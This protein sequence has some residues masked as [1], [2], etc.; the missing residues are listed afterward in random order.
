MPPSI[1][2]TGCE[3]DEDPSMDFAA[4]IPGTGVI[5][6]GFRESPPRQQTPS[7]EVEPPTDACCHT[8]ASAD[9]SDTVSDRGES[10]SAGREGINGP[11]SGISNPAWLLRFGSG[12]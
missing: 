7:R 1:S 6:G 4:A 5:P 2:A 11:P 12:K 10:P 9:K 3:A 8:T